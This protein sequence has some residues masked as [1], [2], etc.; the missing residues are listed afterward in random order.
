MGFRFRVL[1]FQLVTEVLRFTSLF[2]AG[3]VEPQLDL[4]SSAKRPTVGALI[5]RIGF[6]GILCY[7]CNKETQNKEGNQLFRPLY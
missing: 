5:I 3:F 1:G 6:W 2:E 4:R 7:N